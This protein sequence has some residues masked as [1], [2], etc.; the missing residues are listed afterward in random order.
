MRINSEEAFLSSPSLALLCREMK[1][2]KIKAAM[3]ANFFKVKVSQHGPNPSNESSNNYNSI[4]P[5]KQ[6]QKN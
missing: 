6:S 5:K 3:F 1:I 4:H 2:M